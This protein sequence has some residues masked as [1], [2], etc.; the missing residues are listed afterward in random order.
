MTFSNIHMRFR[1]VFTLVLIA[2][3]T[4]SSGGLC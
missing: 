4:H 1:P 2:S 3:I